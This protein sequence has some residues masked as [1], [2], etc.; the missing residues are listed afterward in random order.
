MAFAGCGSLP[1]WRLLNFFVSRSV[2]ASAFAMAAAHAEFCKSCKSCKYAKSRRKAGWFFGG[3]IGRKYRMACNVS[4]ITGDI[5]TKS[6]LD[7]SES[8]R[9]KPSVCSR[10]GATRKHKSPHAAFS[11]SLSILEPSFPR[12][13]R[14]WKLLRPCRDC[15]LRMGGNSFLRSLPA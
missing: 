2:T 4:D 7:K 8:R 1:W 10:W 9:V 5:L 3:S 6:V 13:R 12:N 11:F 14:W 15:L